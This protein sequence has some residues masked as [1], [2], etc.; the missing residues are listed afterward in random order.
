[1]NRMSLIRKVLTTSLLLA[2]GT[3]MSAAVHAPAHAAAASGPGAGHASVSD[4]GGSASPGGGGFGSARPGGSGTG[5]ARPGGSGT[6]SASP[7]G[8]RSKSARVARPSCSGASCTG[9]SPVATG[10]H[11]DARTYRAYSR[12][13]GGPRFYVRYSS[14][15]HTAW[16]LQARGDSGWRVAIQIRNGSS[17][18]VSA[19]PRSTTHTRMVY[20]SLPYRACAKMRNGKW[21]CTNWM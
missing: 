5:S 19:S 7:G 10:C 3:G 12:P 1:M 17:Y 2:L 20:S 4:P 21:A 13:G 15:C 8:S 18:L 6:G 14:R 9:R 11:R 16:V